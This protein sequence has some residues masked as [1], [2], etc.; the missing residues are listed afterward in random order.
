MT[1]DALGLPLDQARALFPG[2]ECRIERTLP[3]RRPDKAG[4]ARVVRACER[5]ETVVLTV[6]LF[7]DKPKEEP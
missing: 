4:S 2:R 1:E 3:P 5:G 6:S 7:E